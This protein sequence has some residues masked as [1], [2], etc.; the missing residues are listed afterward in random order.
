MAKAKYLKDHSTRRMQALQASLRCPH[1]QI[2]ED[3]Y[4]GLAERLVE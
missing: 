1:F 4:H 2:T 3:K